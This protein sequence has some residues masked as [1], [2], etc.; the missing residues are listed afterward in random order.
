MNDAEATACVPHCVFILQFELCFARS[1]TRVAQRQQELS[2][3]KQQQLL[4]QVA[5]LQR[6]L[7]KQTMNSDQQQQQQQSVGDGSEV[8]E[9]IKRVLACPSADPT[10]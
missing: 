9:G 7:E 3:L 5:Q 6:Q 4:V 8:G 1:Q 2:E 10:V